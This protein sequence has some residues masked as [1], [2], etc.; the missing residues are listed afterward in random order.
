MTAIS[1]LCLFSLRCNSEAFPVKTLPLWDPFNLAWYSHILLLLTPYMVIWF[2][3]SA[4]MRNW[5]ITTIT[6]SLSFWEDGL[7][8]NE[9]KSFQHTVQVESCSL[10]STLQF[11]AA[12]V[13][14]IMERLRSW[15]HMISVRMNSKRAEVDPRYWADNDSHKLSFTALCSRIYTV[16]RTHCQNHCSVMRF[17]V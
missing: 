9:R 8:Y 5:K 7:W 12:F 1:G 2:C 16:K 17:H 14:W 11:P 13:T 15:M 4:H 6:T 10:D 3:T